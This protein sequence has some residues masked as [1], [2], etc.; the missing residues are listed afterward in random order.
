[1]SKKLNVVIICIDLGRAD[2]MSCYGFKRVTTPNID[3]IAKKGI[4][5]ESV[6]ATSPWTIPSHAS[7]FTS[8][9]P[10]QHKADWDT[11]RINHGIPTIFEIFSNIGYETVACSGNTI[12]FSP[13]NMF[14]KSTR[15]LNQIK[16]FHPNLSIFIDGFNPG[17][18]NSKMI[19]N[20]FINY[21]KKYNFSRPFLAYLNFYDLH[22]KYPV[23]EPFKS[24]F[25]SSKEK[26][27]L[28]SLRDIYRLHFKEMSHKIKITPEIISALRS[29]YCAKLNM[30]DDDIKRIFKVLKQKK[31]FSNT[32]L[33]ITSDHGDILGDHKYPSFHHQFSI[34]DSVLNIPL[35]LHCPNFFSHP[36]KIRVPLIQ[37]IDI[38]PTI[39]EICGLSLK[40]FI[41]NSPGRSLVKYIF[42][43]NSAPPRKFAISTYKSPE[44]LLIRTKQK[45]K[46]YYLRN[47]NAIRDKRYKLIFYKNKY[48]LYDLKQD[49]Y[50]RENIADVYPRKIIFLKNKFIELTKRYKEMISQKV[51]NPYYSKDEKNILLK[52][53]KTLGY[54]E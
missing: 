16:R 41:K 32:L 40:R 13:H 9:Y 35:I 54:F 22:S 8:L 26:Q 43:D 39:L 12:L 42:K 14:G 48:A 3:Q 37:N 4:L 15:L 19:S 49:K 28:K 44:K 2:Y 29:F 1:M 30:I 36:K 17:K 21:I 47:L 6:T 7:M 33:I 24:R 10:C 31:V 18:S 38:L 52:R 23:R 25:I 46:P 50:E 27:I 51:E 5:F 53:L 34:Y 20:H 11:L 45:V